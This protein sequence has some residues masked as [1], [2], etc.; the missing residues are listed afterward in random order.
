M[1]FQDLTSYAA[2]SRPED[3]G[4]FRYICGP[5]ASAKQ[6]SGV[7]VIVVLKPVSVVMTRVHT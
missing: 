4:S 1:R 6:H 2:I 5:H 7:A 3:Q